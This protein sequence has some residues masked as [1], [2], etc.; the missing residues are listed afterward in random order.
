[1][2]EMQNL[3]F[4]FPPRVKGIKIFDSEALFPVGKIY[5]I[6][7]N[8]ADHAK[9]MGGAVDRDQ[10]FFFSKPPQSITQ[11][12]TIS[13]PTQTNNLHHEVELVVFIGAKC[14]DIQKED[15]HES[16]FGYGVGV[17]LTKRDLQD[18]AKKNRKPW[19]LSKGFDNSAPISKIV[20]NEKNVIRQGEIKLS[21]NGVEKQ[22]SNL[23][24][25]AWEVDEII[26]WL[27]RFIT[28]NPGD[29]IFTGT[30]AGVGKL[31][32]GDEID[33][34]IESVGSLSFKLV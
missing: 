10:P 7:K 18:I 8:Y 5:C 9:E 16:I 29:I 26:S 27:S 2:S 21:V 11:S 24:N 33:A 25:M 17:D 22:S 3:K 1:M 6:G 15:A 19:D 14:S 34:S 13:F 31:N 30:P 12:S 20:Q 23:S 28:L 4:L 32:P